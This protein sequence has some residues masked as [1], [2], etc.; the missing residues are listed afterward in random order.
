MA[1]LNRKHGFL[2]LAEPHC[3]ARSIEA[4]L[5]GRKLD[6]W[7]HESYPDLI[8]KGLVEESWPVFKFSVVRH[9]GDYL[10]T[11]YHHLTSWHK[12][13]FEAFLLSQ[14]ELPT[15]F[16]HASATD[17]VIRYEHLASQLNDVLEALGAPT[18]TL[19]RLGETADKRPW[20]SYY[21]PEQREL[22]ATF[23]DMATYG[24]R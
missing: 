5:P 15:L 23:P 2:F 17:R 21:G 4:A 19:S 13:G 1:V 24:Y 16:M 22:L 18:V 12:A 7:I 14:L 3:A 10:V 6:A 8:R 11:K 9:P 20:E